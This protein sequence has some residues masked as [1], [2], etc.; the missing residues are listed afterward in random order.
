[1]AQRFFISP[2]VTFAGKLS[3]NRLLLDVCPKCIVFK[4]IGVVPNGHYISHVERVRVTFSQ[5]IAPKNSKRKERSHRKEQLLH[6]NHWK[7]H[8]Q[9]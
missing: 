6:Y 1:M 5:L 3:D 8:G 4:A 2:S 9:A 7:Y